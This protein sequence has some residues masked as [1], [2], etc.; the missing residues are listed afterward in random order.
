MASPRL[1]RE[2]ALV[3]S[4]GNERAGGGSAGVCRLAMPEGTPVA[5][6]GGSGARATPAA[7]MPAVPQAATRAYAAG[8]RM[9]Q[10][11]APQVC[12]AAEVELDDRSQ[13]TPQTGG[14]APGV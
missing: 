4:D 12:K 11:T 10:A 14:T 5:P 1:A 8:R 2:A 13:S 3:A 7:R 6:Q 9:L